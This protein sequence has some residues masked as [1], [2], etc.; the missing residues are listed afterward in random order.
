MNNAVI[1][2]WAKVHHA[3]PSSVILI[4]RGRLVDPEIRLFILERFSK[5]GINEERV[6]LILGA[7]V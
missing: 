3:N 5:A 4:C 1:E 7:S 2:L 6:S